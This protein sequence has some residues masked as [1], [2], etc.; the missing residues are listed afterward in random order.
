MR[1]GDADATYGPVVVAVV[2][3]FD[4]FFFFFF[5]T[6]AVFCLPSSAGKN[7]K[8]EPQNHASRSPI[9]LRC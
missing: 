1:L 9:G 2:A 4:F 7:R 8:K 3:V 6:R 5:F